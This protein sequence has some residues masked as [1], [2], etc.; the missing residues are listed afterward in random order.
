MAWLVSVDV[1][2]EE[3]DDV[4]VWDELVMAEFV[5]VGVVVIVEAVVD[6]AVCVE[7][8]MVPVEVGLVVVVVDEEVPGTDV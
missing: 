4:L 3:V 1:T 8:V 6:D 2:V 7:A 5:V